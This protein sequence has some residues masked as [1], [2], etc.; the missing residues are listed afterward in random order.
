MAC[1]K[2]QK[3]LNG[4]GKD[5]SDRVSCCCKDNAPAENKPCCAQEMC[6][7]DSEEHKPCCAQNECGDDWI[8]EMDSDPSVIAMN[9]HT[10]SVLEAK[11]FPHLPEKFDVL[12]IGCGGGHLLAELDKKAGRVVGVDCEPQCLE[13]AKARSQAELVLGWWPKVQVEGEFDLVLVTYAFHGVDP[14]SR[15]AFVDGVLKVMKPGGVLILADFDTVEGE[16]YKEAFAAALTA[17]KSVEVEETDIADIA[18]CACEDC[19]CDDEEVELTE[20]EAK[21]LQEALDAEDDDDDDDLTEEELQQIK[22]A[23]ELG[24]LDVGDEEEWDASKVF[25]SILRM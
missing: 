11:A 3:L 22:K 15:K 13:N 21:Q 1:G 12:E 24:D 19:P 6:C 18:G 9:M 25:I 10:L 2:K 20:E 14:D 17:A 8:D 7:T 23:M 16:R 5:C 4:E